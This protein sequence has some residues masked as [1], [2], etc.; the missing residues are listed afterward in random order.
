MPCSS[1]LPSPLALSLRPTVGTPSTSLPA[2][3]VTEPSGSSISSKILSIDVRL[4]NSAASLPVALD[5]IHLSAS[6]GLTDATGPPLTYIVL[7]TCRSSIFSPPREID[8][9][10]PCAL[11]TVMSTSKDSPSSVILPFMCT[12]SAARAAAEAFSRICC[13]V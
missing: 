2:T 10:A 13:G 12:D 3:R 6:F 7:P 9:P 8:P 5:L 11:L 4:L 1:V